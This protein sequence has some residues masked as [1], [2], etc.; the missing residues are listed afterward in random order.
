MAY[1]RPGLNTHTEFQISKR[2][3]QLLHCCNIKGWD[4]VQ[5]LRKTL[6]GMTRTTLVQAQRERETERERK[7][8]R[9]RERGEG[10]RGERRIW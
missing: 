5:T 8:D 3:L 4:V 2:M 7:R 1:D 9:E 6:H 10:G